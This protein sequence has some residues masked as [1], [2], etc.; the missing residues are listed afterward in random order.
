VIN[1]PSTRTLE[2]LGRPIDDLVAS[3]CKHGVVG[4]RRRRDVVRRC[5]RCGDKWTV[6][7]ALAVA[8]RVS[9]RQRGVSARDQLGFRGVNTN[10]AASMQLDLAKQ[11]G[12]GLDARM[13][14]V[15]SMRTCP[16][17]GVVGSF[18]ETPA[19]RL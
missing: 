14:M 8:P 5:S 2:T 13:E 15:S 7:G 11:R 18:T 12:A 6:P 19:P 16:G 9:R 4:I 17:C 1:G 10:A 3:A